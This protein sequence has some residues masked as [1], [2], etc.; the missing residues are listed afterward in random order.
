MQPKTFN[1]KNLTYMNSNFTISSQNVKYME[2]TE[3]LNS[4]LTTLRKYDALTPEEEKELFRKYHEEGDM[5]A[6]DQIFLHNQRF[7]YSNAKIYARDSGEVMDYVGEGNIALDEAIDKFD[8]SLGNK[9]ITFAV[10]YIRRAMN[11]Y[12]I[13]T[14]DMITKTNGMKLFKK[15]DKIMQKYFSE[16]GCNPTLDEVRDILEKEYNIEVKDVSDLYDLNITSINTDIDDDF[17]I[18]ESNEYCARTASVNEYESEV[19]KEYSKTLANK[20]LSIIPDE[21]KE[22]IKKIYGIGYD[23]QYSIS[24]LAQEYK[25][26]DEDMENLEDKILKYMKQNM[27]QLNVAM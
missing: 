16:H 7:I 22:I 12:L 18:E 14:R 27:G 23:R 4:F 13:N 1:N 19:D 10:W 26:S 5:S 11:Y 25:I 2:G 8:P 3:N 17:E 20:L 9:F 15:T 21:H 24:E 6:R